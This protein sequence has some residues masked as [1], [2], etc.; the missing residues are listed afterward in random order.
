[1]YQ[2]HLS[3]GE[4][5]RYPVCSK[6]GRRKPFPPGNFI[7]WRVR[8]RMVVVYCCCRRFLERGYNVETE[9]KAVIYLMEYHVLPQFA[10]GGSSNVITAATTATTTATRQPQR[11]Q[12]Q[13]QQQQFTCLIDVSGIR[14]PPLS[15]LTHLNSVMEANDPELLY[16]TILF[17]VPGFVQTMIG[18]MLVPLVDPQ[19]PEASLA[20]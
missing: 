4:P 6:K 10:A 16:K 17:P 13:Q 19:M 14:S 15:F 5:R 7:V 9:T 20:T 2:A 3:I 1:M 11:Q 8:M 18:G 12:Q